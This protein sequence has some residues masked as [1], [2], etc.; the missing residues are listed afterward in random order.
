M[1]KINVFALYFLREYFDLWGKCLNTVYDVAAL[2]EEKKTVEDKLKQELEAER[3]KDKK[4]TEE[5]LQQKSKLEKVW[6]KYSLSEKDAVRV[7]QGLLT[8][9]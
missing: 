4:L 1:E 3:E 7:K 9:K 6:I 2:L 5:L 8:S